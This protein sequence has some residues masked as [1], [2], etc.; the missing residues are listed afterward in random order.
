MKYPA[1]AELDT[2]AP[3]L[4]LLLH[5]TPLTA[6]QWQRSCV[7][8]FANRHVT[9]QKILILLDEIDCFDNDFDGCV[10]FSEIR[11]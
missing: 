8:G 11:T 6:V 4:L 2:L 9:T 7:A 10:E 5:L 3:L 1:H